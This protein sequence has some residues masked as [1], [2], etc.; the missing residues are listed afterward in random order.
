M[1]LGLKR[2]GAVDDAWSGV[3]LRWHDA[4]QEHA[5]HDDDVFHHNWRRECAVGAIWF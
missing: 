4:S 5:Q 1:G 3:F 2:V